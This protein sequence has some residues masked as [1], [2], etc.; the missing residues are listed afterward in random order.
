MIVQVCPSKT[1]GMCGYSTTTIGSV[2]AAGYQAIFNDYANYYLGMS[3]GTVTW[4]RIYEVEP[5]AGIDDPEQQKLVVGAEICK[6]VRTML[7]SPRPACVALRLLTRG[8][9]CRAR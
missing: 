4:D 1:V 8:T 6:W 5:L 9:G 2:V 3:S 7:L